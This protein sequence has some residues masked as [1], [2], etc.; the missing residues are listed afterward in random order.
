M[1]NLCLYREKQD[2]KIVN[3]IHLTIEINETA[4]HSFESAT[5]IIV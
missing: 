5:V 3:T 2:V 4:V 1:C